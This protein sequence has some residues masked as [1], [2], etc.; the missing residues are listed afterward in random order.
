[1]FGRNM[2]A[3]LLGAIVIVS[4]NLFAQG[5]T[6]LI[7][8]KVVDQKKN[9]LQGVQVYA[10]DGD[11]IVGKSKTTVTGEF[12]M[13]LKPGKN[14]VMTFDRSDILLSQ[15]D[16]RI[17]NGNTYQEIIQEFQVRVLAKGDTI[18]TFSLFANG[19]S[20]PGPSTIF[21]MLP[22]LLRR[23]QHLKV[24]IVVSA[25]GKSKNTST[26]KKEKSAKK[27]KSGKGAST[28]SSL[29]LTLLDKRIQEIRSKLIAAGAPESR[30]L[31]EEGKLSGANDVAVLITSIVGGF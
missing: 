24:K 5:V 2:I 12:A 3:V 9:P 22:D 17:P 6:F 29:P 16:F 7:K 20:I 21:T 23:M 25:G 31:F 14:Y 1:M 19:Q 30:I 15:Q 10:K 26:N 4:G 27:S 28:E 13:T 11:D 8:G 18:Q